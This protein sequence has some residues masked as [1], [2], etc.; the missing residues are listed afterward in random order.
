M[1]EKQEIY[2]KA[3]ELIKAH[4]SD[5]YA[6]YLFGSFVNSLESP[7]SDLDLAILPKESVDPVAL[8]E[9]SEKIARHINRDVD[10]ID[11][12]QA[13]TVFR[14]QITSTAK[15]IYCT[16]KKYCDRM[17]NNWDSAYLRFNIE[18]REIIK[19]QQQNS[20]E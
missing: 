16:D 17:E 7:H 19:D 2:Q 13:S 20:R 18:R 12:T 6:I 4:C 10:L 9:L 15:R 8:W 3:I 14:F 11:L 1:D 5:I